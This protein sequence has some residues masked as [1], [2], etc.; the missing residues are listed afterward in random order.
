MVHSDEKPYIC[1][2]INCE[3]KFNRIDNLK[4]HA[5]SHQDERSFNDNFSRRTT[6][7]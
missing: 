6:L 1:K 3:S 4:K 2:I 5:K 7:V